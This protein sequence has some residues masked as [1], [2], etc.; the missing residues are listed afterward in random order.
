LSAN[1]I[2]DSLTYGCDNDNTIV[3]GGLMMRTTY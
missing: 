1:D 2:C 3:R